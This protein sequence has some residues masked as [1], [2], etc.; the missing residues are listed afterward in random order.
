MHSKNLISLLL[1]L[2]QPQCLFIRNHR[3]CSKSSPNILIVCFK[4]CQLCFTQG[5]LCL[6][7]SQPNLKNQSLSHVSSTWH[8]LKILL[9]PFT[10]SLSVHTETNALEIYIF[11]SAISS[12]TIKNKQKIYNQYN[13]CTFVSLGAFW[14]K[15]QTFTAMF[16]NLLE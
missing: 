10:Y 12:Q 7:T 1:V 11:Y 2:P 15:R 16:E 4:K 8:H 9:I 13:C 5:L 3:L 14:F 6:N